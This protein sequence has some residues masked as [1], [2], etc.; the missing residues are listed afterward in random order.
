M[1]VVV[2]IRGLRLFSLYKDAK[3]YQNTTKFPPNHYKNMTNDY[4]KFKYY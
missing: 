1:K 2:L 4:R 3:Y